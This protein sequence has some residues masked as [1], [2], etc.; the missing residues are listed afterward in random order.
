MHSV[1]FLCP[2]T[3]FPQRKE[4]P[5]SCSLNQDFM[6]QF[7]VTE[8]LHMCSPCMHR[9]MFTY[10]FIFY[11]EY[12]C[13]YLCRDTAGQE[14]FKTITT[15]YYRGAMV[16]MGRLQDKQTGKS[17]WHHWLFVL[18]LYL[19]LW[20]PLCFLCVR[21]SSWCMTS[22]TRSPLK[23]SRTGWRASKKWDI[24]TQPR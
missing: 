7:I 11:F 23:T 1:I 10:V 6:T 19:C 5:P 16:S 9:C 20:M 13:L 12:V 24:S 15:A 8:I 2:L 17:V 4:E 21:A 18:V 14:R 3:L 22:Q